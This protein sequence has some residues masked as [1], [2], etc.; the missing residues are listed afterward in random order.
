MEDRHFA[1]ASSQIAE[2]TTYLVGGWAQPLLKNDGV[3]VSWDDDIPNIY[4]KIKNVPNHQPVIYICICICICICI[5]RYIC[6]H[7]THVTDMQKAWTSWC[8]SAISQMRLFCGGSKSRFLGSFSRAS[9]DMWAVLR[10]LCPIILVGWEQ[11]YPFMDRDI[12]LKKTFS[13]VQSL[14]KSSTNHHL[15]VVSWIM[16]YPLY[17]PII[18]LIVEML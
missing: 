7:N 16:L 17:I 2:K 10:T 8:T 9:I 18:S 14:N 4:G 3:K 13:K 5:Y 1:P 6:V 12:P 11:D 15:P